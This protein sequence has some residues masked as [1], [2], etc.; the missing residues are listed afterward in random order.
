MRA[1][2]IVN[3]AVALY[4]DC[5]VFIIGDIDKGGVFASLYGTNALISDEER[6][7][8]RGFIINKFRGDAEFVGFRPRS[9]EGTDRRGGDRCCAVL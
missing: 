9:V 7:L 6:D 3:M 2:D 5:P 8:V 4:A 1:G